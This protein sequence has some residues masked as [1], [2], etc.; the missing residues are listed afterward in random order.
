MK[1]VL[2]WFG[3]FLI[4]LPIFSR[5]PNSTQ[6]RVATLIFLLTMLPLGILYGLGILGGW[7]RFLLLVYKTK[8]Q[9]RTRLH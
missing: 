6:A 5:W 8:A 3:G 9:N 7:F 4:W 2:I 1:S